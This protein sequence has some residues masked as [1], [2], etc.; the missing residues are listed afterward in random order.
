VRSAEPRLRTL[1]VLTVVVFGGGGFVLIE[2]VQGR[3]TLA[4][5]SGPWPW[6]WQVL[7]GLVV[8]GVIAFVAW[9]LIGTRWMGAIRERY[10]RLL[11]PHIGDPWDRMFISLC[12][13]VGEELF[14]RGAVQ[15]WLGIPLTAVVFV[16][17][18]GYLDPRDRRLFV[19]GLVL[20]GGM[21]ALGHMAETHGLLGP[22]LAHALID[23]VLLHQLNRTWR[24]LLPGRV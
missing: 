21:I 2:W 15:A 19:Y 11:G 23:V 6:W 16:A 24:A 18:H 7:E 10:A 5:L 1:A 20:T 9:T 13:G 17:V 8:G 3:S 14:F 4:L 22:M 12:A